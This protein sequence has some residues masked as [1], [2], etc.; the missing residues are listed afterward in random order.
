MYEKSSKIYEWQ[1]CENALHYMEIYMETLGKSMRKNNENTSKH[2]NLK[3][4]ENL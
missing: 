3:T 1:N 2:F 4:Y